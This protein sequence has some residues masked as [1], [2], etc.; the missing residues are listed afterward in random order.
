ML[1]P[2]SLLY[3]EKHSLPESQGW[4]GVKLASV[5]VLLSHHHAS[6]LDSAATHLADLELQVGYQSGDHVIIRQQQAL[7][8]VA[9]ARN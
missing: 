2:L 9:L 8:S 5:W 1:L 4:L 7:D 6:R 3:F